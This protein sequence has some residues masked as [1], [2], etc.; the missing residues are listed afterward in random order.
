VVTEKVD[1]RSRPSLASAG[2][3]H[4]FRDVEVAWRSLADPPGRRVDQKT[5]VDFNATKGR[6]SA[7]I[8]ARTRLTSSAAPLPQGLRL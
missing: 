7:R 2:Q 3:P 1:D 5:I 6:A 8:S 4:E